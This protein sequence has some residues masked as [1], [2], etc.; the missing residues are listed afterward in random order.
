MA[1]WNEARSHSP[2]RFDDVFKWAEV[3]AQHKKEVNERPFVVRY[4]TWH[5]DSSS[6]TVTVVDS[7]EQQHS[8]G[9]LNSAAPE[10]SGE[11]Q[12]SEEGSPASVSKD[13]VS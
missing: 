7:A 6:T 12:N 4:P 1:S 5:L 2:Q 10:T 3:I 8:L 11:A 9:L 13:H